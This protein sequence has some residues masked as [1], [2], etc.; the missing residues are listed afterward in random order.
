M[1]A[2][3]APAIHACSK[4]G[5]PMQIAEDVKGADG[6]VIARRFVCACEGLTYYNW[7]KGQAPQ[8]RSKA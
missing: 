4:C 7:H 6:E 1:E 3:P 2:N 8:T 5:K